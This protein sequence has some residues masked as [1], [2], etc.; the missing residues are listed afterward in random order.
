MASVATAGGREIIMG[1]GRRKPDTVVCPECNYE[2]VNRLKGRCRRCGVRLYY[3]HEC[4]DWKEKGYFYSWG[5]GWI[6]LD[7]L[8]DEVKIWRSGERPRF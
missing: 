5:E 1:H 8:L 3:S 2:S 7:R 4:I 6:T